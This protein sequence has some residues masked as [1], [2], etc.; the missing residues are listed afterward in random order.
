VLSPATPIAHADGG[1]P[2][3][4]YIAGSQSGISVIDI[5]QQKVITNFSLVGKP[6]TLYLSLDGRFLYVTQPEIGRVT[7]LAAKTG[8]TI[9]HVAIAGQ[10][11]LLVFDPFSSILYTAGNHSANVTAFSPANCT[12][13]HILPTT[14][15]VYGLAVASVGS[16]NSDDQLWVSDASGLEIFTNNTRTAS[17]PLPDRPEYICIPPG[18]SAYVTTQHGSVYAVDLSTHQVSP[19]LLTG[20]QFGPMDYDAYT[21]QVFI[22]D[23]QNRRLDVL[24]PVSLPITSLPPE[25]GSTIPL[26]AAPQSVAITSDGQL[27]FVA[28]GDGQIAMLDILGRDLIST[29]SVGGSP[30]FVITGL[31]PPLLGTTP[32]QASTWNI[33]LIVVTCVIVLILL[34]IPVIFITGF[35]RTPATHK[36][37]TSAHSP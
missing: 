16:G 23:K 15:P 9:C 1:A 8:Q 10:P 34:I 20:G 36:K 11:S 2:D 26:E 21:D 27:G 37:R 18:S 17:I 31:Y 35:L 32:Q 25:P 5:H 28:L 12:T 3:L 6:E 13:S 33:L 30:Q 14:G 24:T 4:A 29:I 7:M 22:P 19:P